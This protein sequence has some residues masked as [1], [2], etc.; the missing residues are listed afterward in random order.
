MTRLESSEPGAGDPSEAGAPAMPTATTPAAPSARRWAIVG[1]V[2]IVALI[3]AAGALSLT[4]GMH[5]AWR[6]LVAAVSPGPPPKMLLWRDAQGAIR[7][8][9]VDPVKYEELA[10]RQRRTLGWAHIETRADART[11]IVA[12]TAAVFSEIEDR[13]PQYGEWYYRYTTKYVLMTHGAMGFWNEFWRPD[14]DTPFTVAETIAL[15]QDHLEAYLGE[16]YAAD[17]LHPPITEAELQSDYDR[18]LAALHE[19]WGKI[20][21]DENQLFAKFLDTQNSTIVPPDESAGIDDQKLDWDFRSTDIIHKD[22]ITVRKFRRGLLSI[23]ISRP[24]K[25][26]VAGAPAPEPDEDPNEGT[27]EISHVIANLFSAVIDP[28]SAQLSALLA[29]TVAGGL[30]G[31][32]TGAMV[33]V[34]PAAVP[35]L[36]LSAPLL[37]AVIGAAITVSTDI[38]STRL[39][40]HMTRAAFEQNLRD[41]LAKTQKEITDNLVAALYE[42]ADAQFVEA[43]HHLGP[44]PTTDK[45]P[46]P[47][48]PRI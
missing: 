44:P 21:A 4:D 10:T 18:D 35:G 11:R 19:D 15:I 9:A 13:I 31:A 29:G 6:S 2:G 27:D 47:I 7:K 26:I 32:A 17:V 30:A 46:D 34:P 16:Q 22:R 3:V 43:S 8:A 20:V 42:H 24:A 38:A 39:E 14:R 23:A 37:G 1:G 33:T 48:A 41:T 28:L 5:P 40:E 25:Y 45:K 12:D 36:A